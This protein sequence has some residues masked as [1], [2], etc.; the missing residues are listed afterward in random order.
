MFQRGPHSAESMRPVKPLISAKHNSGSRCP[1]NDTS[2]QVVLACIGCLQALQMHSYSLH[3]SMLFCPAVLPQMHPAPLARTQH[4]VLK[5]LGMAAVMGILNSVPY[6]HPK[7]HVAV[8]SPGWTENSSLR[9]L[10]STYE[11]HWS[12]V[13]QAM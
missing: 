1:T 10:P 4:V 3:G 7:L 9:M 13:Q 11:L 8:R 2:Q 12:R 6:E 5:T